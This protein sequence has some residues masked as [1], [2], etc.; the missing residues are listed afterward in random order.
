MP[1]RVW[2]SAPAPFE[3]RQLDVAPLSLRARPSPDAL[4]FACERMGVA[5]ADAASFTH[6]PAG[7]AA[8]RAAGT[9]VVGVGAVTDLLECAGAD[10][11]V[12]ALDV[13]LDS[14]LP[15]DR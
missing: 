5:A 3:Y 11:V 7:V 8:G 2:P 10:I 12:P 1:A 13:L 4:L 6:T 14:R 15:A 9:V